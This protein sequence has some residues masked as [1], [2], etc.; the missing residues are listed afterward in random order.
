MANYIA[1]KY[2]L[3]VNY[4]DTGNIAAY[5]TAS[6]IFI[7]LNK[8]SIEEP[9]HELMHLIL[10]TL[11]AK[12]YNTYYQI[13]QS[14]QNHP[15]F[16]E[17]SRL[18][19]EEINI[20]KLEETFV[21]LLSKTFRNKILTEGIFTTEMFDE[22]FK[23]TIKELFNLSSDLSSVDTNNLLTKS[24]NELM[25]VFG[26]RLLEETNTLIDTNDNIRMLQISNIIKTMRDNNNLIENCK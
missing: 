20:D 12:D 22:A 3:K 9:V 6:D 16:Q 5:A 10:T 26:S 14:I 1:D 7:N 17:V 13:I 2:G 18:Y 23:N 4:I 8:A 21:K 15:L 11:K 25:T 19:D 24:V